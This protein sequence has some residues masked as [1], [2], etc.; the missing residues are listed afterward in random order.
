MYEEEKKP[1]KVTETNDFKELIESNSLYI[2]KTLLIKEI[3]DNGDKSIMIPR[4][5]R[6]GKTL[7]L[8][9]LYYYFSNEFDSYELF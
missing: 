6:F 2:D 3:I 1:I 8:S 5:R 9:M 4:P 7:N